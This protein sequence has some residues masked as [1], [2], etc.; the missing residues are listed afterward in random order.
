MEIWIWV[1]GKGVG[2]EEVPKDMGFAVEF[3]GP[4]CLAAVA[5]TLVGRHDCS[6]LL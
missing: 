1:D 5:F 2:R 4:F 3:G 6:G